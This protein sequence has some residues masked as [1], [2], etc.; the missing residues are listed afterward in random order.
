MNKWLCVP[1]ALALIMGCDSG[2]DSE[3]SEGN[4]GSQ[5][6]VE[7]VDFAGINQDG[8]DKLN[9]TE[10]ESAGLSSEAFRDFDED[11]DELLSEAEASQYEEAKE[12][13][14]PCDPATCGSADQCYLSTCV[15]GKGECVS[16]VDEGGLGLPCDDGD[17]CT[18]SEYCQ[19]D[20]TCAIFGDGKS[21][22]EFCQF[23]DQNQGKDIGNHVKNF[24]M[25]N[26]E[27]CPYWMHQN[28]GT[29]KKVIWMILSTGW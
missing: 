9:A 21:G 25:K 12:T 1:L 11:G 10:W 26:Y 15:G 3:N 5:A 2:G 19:Q 14:Q 7:A 27:G 28:C 22:T 23:D 16:K 24:G 6:V 18:S 20:G 17:G 8:D 13:Y 29:E 4:S